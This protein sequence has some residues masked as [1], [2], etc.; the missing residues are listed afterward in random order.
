[1]ETVIKPLGNLTIP[2]KEIW[3][4]REVIYF[5]ALK[6]IY[7]RYQHKPIA[8]FWVTLNPLI[9][10][11]VLSFVFG[12]TSISKQNSVPYP[13]LVLIGLLYWNYFSSTLSKVSISLILNQQLITHV[14]F[15]RLLLP[16]SALFIGLV[17]L[18]F[19]LLIFLLGLLY[20]QIPISIWGLLLMIPLLGLTML[21]SLG[22]GLLFSALQIKYKDSRELLPFVAYLLFFLTPVF[23]PKIII[24]GNLSQLLYLNPMT[25]VIEI[26]RKTFFPDLIAHPLNLSGLM[27]SILSG[28]IILIL[29]L[30]YFNRTERELADII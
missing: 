25:G 28:L 22:L 13:L 4:R 29:G 11:L 17:D 10:T 21:T 19:V 3:D 8:I 16:L 7:L 20:F 23:Y 30:A 15:P 12:Q 1:M 2:W 6:D 26:S 9:I 5:F 18:F 14:Y 27:I 24:P